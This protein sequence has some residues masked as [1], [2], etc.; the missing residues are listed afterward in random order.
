MSRV[1]AFAEAVAA[2]VAAVPG[3]KHADW[4]LG[5]F[6]LEDLKRSSQRAPYVRVGVVNTGALR[7]VDAAPSATCQVAAFVVTQGRKAD[8][9]RQAWTIGEAVAVL[10]TAGAQMWGLV[11]LAS[12]TNVRIE[13]LTS[14]GA[15][16]KG[17]AL[18]AVQWSQVLHR[19]GEGVF[20]ADPSAPADL[21][22]GE[23]GE[24]E[25]TAFGPPGEGE[26]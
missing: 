18:L 20:V 11:G 16:D 22:I 12:P 6:D 13:P 3:V 14:A 26:G 9:E 7:M 10:A 8:R 4:Q 17:V 1:I 19:I 25:D 23:D 21:A 2:A 15:D 24:P 5:R